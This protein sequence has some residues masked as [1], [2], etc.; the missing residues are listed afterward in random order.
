VITW[1]LQETIDRPADDVWRTAADVGRHADW[2][3]APGTIKSGSATEVGS[4]VDYVFK[5]GPMTFNAVA[6]VASADPGRR[7]GWRVVDGAPFTATYTLDLE[8][9]GPTTT[10]AGWSGSMQLKGL[11]RLLTPLFAME[12]REGEAKELARLKA[13]VEGSPATPP[14]S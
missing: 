13:L 9:T 4:R 7:I 12:T 14:S 3:G 10:R 2:M 1:H 11:W 8:Q 6:E 5:L